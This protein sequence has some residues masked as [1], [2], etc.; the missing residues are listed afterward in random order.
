MSSLSDKKQIVLVLVIV[1]TCIIGYQFYV[2]RPVPT[3]GSVHPQYHKTD[4][5][6][7]GSNVEKLLELQKELS[8]QIEQLNGKLSEQQ[9]ALDNMAATNDKLLNRQQQQQQR[10]PKPTFLTEGEFNEEKRDQDIS[11]RIKKTKKQMPNTCITTTNGTLSCL[12]NFIIIGTMKSGTTFLDHYLQKHPT[13]ARHKVKEVWFFN[14]HYY[15]GIEW[16]ASNFEQMSLDSQRMIGEGTPFYVNHPHTPARM[17]SAL[18]DVKLILMLRDPVDRCLSQYHFS[19]KWLERNKAP[20][21]KPEYTFDTLIQEEAEVIETCVRGNQE[22]NRRFAQFQQDRADGLIDQDKEFEEINPY[23]EIHNDKGWGF[24]QQC[25]SCDKCFQ[26]G[27]ILHTSGHPTF[28]MLAKS[29]YYEQIEYWLNFYPLS[30]IH[31]IRYEDLN[32][33]P[34]GV[35]RDV[36][37]FLGLDEYKDYGEFIPKNVVAHEEMNPEIREFLTNY[38]REPNER[39]YKLLNRDFG[40]AR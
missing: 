35:I 32:S 13:I 29:L 1:I 5:T 37:Q 27:S 18:K 33:R 12:P 16:Y 40:W 4:N 21:L 26:T 10:V 2:T 34:E 9:E 24:Y 11:D 17:Y 3:N 31:I 7:L 15:K 20:K 25:S 14:S 30:Q 38:F 8:Q 36:E 22:Y 23:T 39:L 6:V 19:I 28:G